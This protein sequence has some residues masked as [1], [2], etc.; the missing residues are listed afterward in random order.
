MKDYIFIIG[1]SGVGKSTLAKGLFEHY[2][3]VYF[4]QNM[5]PEFGI[6][7][8]VDEGRYE[9]EILW[10]SSIELL[11]YFY[12]KGIK[13]IIGLDF[14]DLRTREIPIIFKNTNFITI[15]L[16]SSNYEQNKKQMLERG[17]KG[18]IDFELLEESTKKIMNRY[19]LPNEVIL[20]V[21]NKTK[22]EVLKEAIDIIDSYESKKNY[23]YELPPKELFH[24]WVLS[25]GL[26]TSKR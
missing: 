25:D 18:L 9:E 2:K 22:D 26:R 15:K 7:D 6:P 17:E 20:D 11:K 13:N 5:I 10:E 16:I 19:L 8:N 1:P 14:N 21:A 3:G 4:E 23:D 24:S 12:N